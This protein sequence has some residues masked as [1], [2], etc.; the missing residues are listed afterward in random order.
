MNKY[1]INEDTVN[2]LITISN[3][4]ETNML[5][6]LIQL[7]K[8]ETPKRLSHLKDAVESKN[9]KNIYK[10]S[11]ILKSTSAYLGADM[12]AQISTELEKSAA[13]KQIPRNIN[14]IL[15]DLDHFYNLALDY[16]NQSQAA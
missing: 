16:F 2:K 1:Y 10:V 6:E 3:T 13:E 11:Q 12:I 4:C 9:T 14:S 8:D 5:P 7:F 15:N